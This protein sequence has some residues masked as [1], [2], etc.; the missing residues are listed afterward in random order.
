MVQTFARVICMFSANNKYM[1][2][3]TYQHLL[4]NKFSKNKI[5]V[6]NNIERTHVIINN[7]F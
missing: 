7:L 1:W 6:N 4:L 3:N 5:S 2:N